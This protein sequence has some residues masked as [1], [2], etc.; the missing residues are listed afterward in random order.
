MP[1]FND[2]PVVS[3]ESESQAAVIGT[4]MAT[5]VIG[6]STTWMGVYGSTQSTTG[7]AGVMGEG[8]T[9]GPGV[10]GKSQT[11][12]GVYGETWA[13][14][15]SGAA[16]VWGE[17]KSDGAGVVGHSA[18]GA[19]IYGKS[20]NGEAGHFDGHVVVNGLLE[21]LDGVWG[22]SQTG[23]TPAGRFLGDVDVTGRIHTGG[24]DFAE[25][26]DAQ[27]DAEPGTVLVIEEDGLLAPCRGEYDTRATGV[28]SGAGGLAPG[29]VMQG[30]TGSSHQVTLALAGQV[31]VRA[32]AQYGAL[33]AGDLLTTSPTEGCAMRVA[34]RPRAVGAVI[35]KALSPLTGGIGLVRML[36]V[37]S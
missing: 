37:F 15:K 8:T 17:D 26:F 4:S 20:E 1:E 10:I 30:E 34:D 22:A 33:S 12:H 13:P 5:G 23:G 19:G 25:S 7:G 29:C 2:D 27:G 3:S 35:G 31:Y 6:E 36:V 9:G 11:W 18:E 16:A 14:G 24:S 32:D 28:V 21:G